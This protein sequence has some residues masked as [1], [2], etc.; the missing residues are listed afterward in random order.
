MKAS[1]KPTV[2]LAGFSGVG[3]TFLAQKYRNVLDLE[4]S[5]FFWDY[6]NIIHDS[7]FEKFK[8]SAGRKRNPNYPENFINE[9]KKNIGKYDYILVWAHVDEAMPHYN[10]HNI[11]IDAYFIPSK[12][13]L[14]DYIVRY[15][16]R[17]NTKEYVVKMQERYNF[18]YERRNEISKSIV[19]LEKGETLESYLIK[20]QAQYPI[21]IK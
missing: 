4:S 18:Q 2:I 12:N 11:C 1:K 13:A 19:L 21:L 16:E 9:L 8:G 6:S 3:K 15:Y 20:N 7:D 10:K 5:P 14:D 17:G